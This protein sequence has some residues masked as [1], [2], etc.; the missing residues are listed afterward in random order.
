M[1][2]AVATLAAQLVAGVARLVTWIGGEGVPPVAKI[3]P[4][5]FLFCAV[6][7]GLLCLLLTPLV[8]RLR[9]VKPPRSITITALAIGVAPLIIMAARVVL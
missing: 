2:S 5:W 6:L 7:T 4:A 8:Y 9:R 1:L 3:L